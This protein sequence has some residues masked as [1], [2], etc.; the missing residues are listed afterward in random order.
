MSAREECAR[1][2][3]T[4]ERGEACVR[5]EDGTVRHEVGRCP[6][7]PVMLLAAMRAVLRGQDEILRRLAKVESRLAGEPEVEP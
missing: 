7:A 3:E 2:G 6:H 5:S 1:C 4:V